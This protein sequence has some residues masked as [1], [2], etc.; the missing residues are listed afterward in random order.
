VKRETTSPLDGERAF[1]NRRSVDDHPPH[2]VGMASQRAG[3]GGQGAGVAVD[4]SPVAT[5]ARSRPADAN[6]RFSRNQC[7]S[8][9]C[10]DHQAAVRA[11]A[12][13]AAAYAND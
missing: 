4:A 7:L 8:N 2:L 12:A 3:P 1:R 9:R 13:D 10:Q 5:P 6:S 11:N